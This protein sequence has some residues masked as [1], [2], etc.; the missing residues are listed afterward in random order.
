MKF[1][2]LLPNYVVA[3]LFV[4]LALTLVSTRVA[5]IEMLQNLCTAKCR[6][7]GALRDCSQFLDGGR[8]MLTKLCHICSEDS[9]TEMRLQ[10]AVYIFGVDLTSD[11][12]N[13][14]F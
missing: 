3:N 9:Q 6:R 8:Q 4:Y 12:Q 1:D 7:C 10:T 14:F 13:T 2:I 5:N 11:Q